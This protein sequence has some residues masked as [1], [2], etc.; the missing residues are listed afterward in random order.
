MEIATLPGAPPVLSFIFEDQRTHEEILRNPNLPNPFFFLND[1]QFYLWSVPYFADW[2]MG[3]GVRYALDGDVFG[4]EQGI[5]LVCL[6]LVCLVQSVQGAGP[7]STG[8]NIRWIYTNNEVNMLMSCAVYLVEIVEESL[9]S[10]GH[11]SITRGIKA[12]RRDAWIP[13]A[14]LSLACD[15]IT[16]VIERRLWSV[17]EMVKDGGSRE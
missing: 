12:H 3:G 11:T 10:R 7:K 14:T 6:A 13:Q 8:A 5:E 15:G 1:P 4:G 17:S 2:V 16:E 9:K